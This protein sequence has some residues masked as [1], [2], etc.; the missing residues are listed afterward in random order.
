M[1]INIYIYIYIYIHLH[2]QILIFRIISGSYIHVPLRSYPLH[3]PYT[4]LFPQRYTPRVIDVYRIYIYRDIHIYIYIYIYVYIYMYVYI[5][6]KISGRR[7]SQ[8]Y[9][10]RFNRVLTQLLNNSSMTTNSPRQTVP[11]ASGNS[12]KLEIGK[13]KLGPGN[14]KLEIRNWPL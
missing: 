7:Q 2:R 3:I 8:V 10:T 6:T 4:S 5:Y 13:S 14:C 1:C 12:C 9:L 11:T